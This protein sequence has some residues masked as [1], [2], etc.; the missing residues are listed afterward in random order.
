MRLIDAESHELLARLRFIR[1][2]EQQ[3]Y[4]RES[5]GFT[6]KCEHAIEDAPTIQPEPDIIHCED[7]K[8]FKR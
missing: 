7:C 3:I 4:G 6:A 5:W 2:A 8:Y 1:E